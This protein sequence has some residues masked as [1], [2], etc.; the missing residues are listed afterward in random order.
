LNKKR[1]WKGG[2]RIKRKEGVRFR[3]GKK[4]GKMV[5]A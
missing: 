1:G 5:A 4:E 2:I 3:D